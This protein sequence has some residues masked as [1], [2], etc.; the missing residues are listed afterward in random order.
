MAERLLLSRRDAA[1]ALG[2]SLRTIDY[3]LSRGDLRARPIG[4]RKMV[5]MAELQRFAQRGPRQRKSSKQ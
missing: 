2:V 3:L 1:T 4:R 5:A